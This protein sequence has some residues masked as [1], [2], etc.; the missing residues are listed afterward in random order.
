MCLLPCNRTKDK[1]H[2]REI[3][4]S[5]HFLSENKYYFTD[6]SV[7]SGGHICAPERRLHTWRLHTKL[8]KIG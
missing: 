2:A 4:L 5:K 6:V 7:V 8:Y 1:M 3:L